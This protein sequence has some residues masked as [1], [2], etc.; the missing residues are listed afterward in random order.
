[1]RF[2]LQ[3]ACVSCLPGNDTVPNDGELAAFFKS[4]H[5]VNLKAV[6]LSIAPGYCDSFNPTSHLA[7]LPPLISSY[8]KPELSSHAF[9]DRILKSQM[10]FQSLVVTNE[11]ARC[12]EEKT[13]EQSKSKFWNR[14]R[15]G[16]QSLRKLLYLTL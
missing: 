4:L 7:L 15:A 12:L 11:Q 10:L 14:Y 3:P 5:E 1:M 8:Y 9:I 13:R 16:V 6:I 2:P